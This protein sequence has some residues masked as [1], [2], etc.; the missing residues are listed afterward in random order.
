MTDLRKKSPPKINPIRKSTKNSEIDDDGSDA[1]SE[2]VIEYLKLEEL[3]LERYD[4]DSSINIELS[5][6]NEFIPK[7]DIN[8]VKS[9]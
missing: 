5:D 8:W 2:G 9:A 6:E 1:S 4:S 7:V 3:S